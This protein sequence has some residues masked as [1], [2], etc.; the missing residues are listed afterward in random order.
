MGHSE[1][2]FWGGC[3]LRKLIV[4]LLVVLLTGCATTDSALHKHDKFTKHYEKSLFKVTKK[5]M[6]SVEMVVKENRLKTGLNMVDLIIH[7]KNDRDAI[8][9]DVTVTPWMPEMGHGVFEDPVITE[10]GGGLYA[11]ENIILIMSGHWELRINIKSEG[12]EDNA[13]FDFPDV[14]VDRGYE[15]KMTKAPAPSDL[16][17]STTRF[18]DN[19][20]FNVS[21]QSKLDPIPINKIH[22]WTLI[23]ETADGRQVENAEISIDG[24]MPEHGHGLPTQPEVTDEV[25]DGKYLIEGMKFSMPGWWIM[26][27]NITAGDREDIV[28]FNL[29]LRE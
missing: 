19:K 7:D 15:H 20:T 8:G 6:F 3:K 25:E 29:L 1:N 22:S 18:S 10:K 4:L 11:V 16:D 28:T 2:Q 13:V 14:K 21:F 27:F 24:D 9:A 12:M 26:K 17:L 5:G 23:I